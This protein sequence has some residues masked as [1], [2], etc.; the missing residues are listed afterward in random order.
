MS[1]TAVEPAPGEDRAEPWTLALVPLASWA[2]ID[3]VRWAGRR[4]SRS[5][6]AEDAIRRAIAEDVA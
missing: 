4:P 5:A 6:V 2:V 3:A 1:T